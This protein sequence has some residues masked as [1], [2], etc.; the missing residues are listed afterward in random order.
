[1]YKTITAFLFFALMFSSQSGQAQDYKSAAGLRLGVPLSL[2][3]KVFISENNAIEA[4]VGTRRFGNG[5]GFS[6]TRWFNF[7]GA[8]LLHRDLEIDGIDNLRYYFGPGVGAY[9]FTYNNGFGD[10]ASETVFGVQAYGGVE[11]T[12]EDV[13]VSVSADWVP[14]VLF[15]GFYSGFSAGYG[16]LSVRYVISR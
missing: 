13:P 7:N 15:N 2:S 4:S 1:M 5:F 9:I 3:Y 8:F 6:G 12:F 16:A 11:Y 10:G 14:T